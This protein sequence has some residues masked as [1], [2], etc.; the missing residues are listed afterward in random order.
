MKTGQVIVGTIWDTVPKNSIGFY[1]GRSSKAPSPL[2]NP[3]VITAHCSREKAISLY[4][5]HI[6][7]ALKSRNEPIIDEL[8]EMKEVLLRGQ[9]VFLRCYCKNKACHGDVIKELLDG[10]IKRE[11]KKAN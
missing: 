11:L 4:K 5:V 10:A 6:K 3:H 8:K 7:K 9:N 2:Q 1:I